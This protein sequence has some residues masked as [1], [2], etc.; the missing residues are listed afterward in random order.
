[1]IHSDSPLQLLFTSASIHIFPQPQHLLFNQPKQ[2][3]TTKLA[4]HHEGHDLDTL[5]FYQ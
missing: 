5:S 2:C 3:P 4:L 1:M